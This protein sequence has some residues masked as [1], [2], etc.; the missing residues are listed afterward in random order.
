MVSKWM[1]STLCK[2]V[3][4]RD[5]QYRYLWKL[6]TTICPKI[7]YEYTYIFTVSPFLVG[8]EHPAIETHKF[9]AIGHC[10]RKIIQNSCRG[11][12]HLQQNRNP[13]R[14]LNQINSRCL[15]VDNCFNF[16]LDAKCRKSSRFSH[17]CRHNML[18]K[19]ILQGLVDHVNRG[20]TTSRNGRV[21][22]CHHCSTLQRTGVDG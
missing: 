16:K 12:I 14:K 10:G 9:T 2:I 13:N 21:S 3:A 19:I 7:I 18:P 8:R 6:I 20:R 17:V 22:R 11:K 5:T 4:N 1:H 15:K